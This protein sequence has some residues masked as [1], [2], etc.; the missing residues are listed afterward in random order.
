[1]F[2]RRITASLLSGV[3]V[4][5]LVLSGQAVAAFTAKEA[6]ALEAE[7][8]AT[9][10]K[11]KAETRGA[12]E[13]FANAKGVLVCPQIT[14]G[15]FVFGVESG[16]CVLT[17]GAQKPLYYG[18]SALKFGLLAGIAQYSMILVLNTDTALA[19]FTSGPR[20]WELGADASLAVAKVGA[21]G[22]LDTTNLKK[23]IVSFFLGD[24]GLM[25]DASFSGSRFKKI[26]VE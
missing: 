2:S 16:K 11:L 17:P 14:K 21:G 24:K 18:T 4:V 10:A 22:S 15:G 1:M 25:G 20:E 13:V 8:K 9:L 12:G 3:V 6:A 26:D 5:G 7:A 23:D 19:K